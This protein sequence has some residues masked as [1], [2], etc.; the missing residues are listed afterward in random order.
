M[1]MIGGY[2]PLFIAFI[3]GYIN[4]LL[5]GFKNKEI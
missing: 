4:Y 5:G 2:I 1:N 3:I